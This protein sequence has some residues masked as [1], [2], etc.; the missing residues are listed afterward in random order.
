MDIAI[1]VVLTVLGVVGALRVEPWLR[2]KYRQR[3]LPLVDIS[4]NYTTSTTTWAS[5]ATYEE[6]YPGGP[7]FRVRKDHGHEFEE[8]GDSMVC[9]C[10]NRYRSVS[11]G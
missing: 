3:G 5:G 7:T 1:T 9:S 2:R 4:D 11:S 10:G 8:D 6:V